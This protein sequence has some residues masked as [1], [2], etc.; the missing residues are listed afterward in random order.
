[1]KQ[2]RFQLS[3]GGRPVRTIEELRER[4]EPKDVL[5]AFRDGTLLRWA[6]MRGH[7]AYAAR[8]RGLA[9]MY[10]GADEKRLALVVE[11]LAKE[12]GIK[13][14]PADVAAATTPKPKPKQPEIGYVELVER[15][16]TNPKD[17]ALILQTLRTLVTKMGDAFPAEDLFEA[18]K[19]SDPRLVTY[20]LVCGATRPYYLPDMAEKFNFICRLEN[21]RAM[22]MET[23]FNDI[24]GVA[25]LG[26]RLIQPPSIILKCVGWSLQLRT[27]PRKDAA[28]IG[29]VEPDVLNHLK[30]CTQPISLY[31]ASG[32]DDAIYYLKVEA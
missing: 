14:K 7:E 21:L 31:S 17:S 28:W 8:V 22:V 10:A 1:M 30:V 29:T 25:R 23:R 13:I 32:T 18:L 5:D 12:L 2:I 9:E 24:L 4:F 20:L 19:K 3:L 26:K 11:A 6:E 16:C 15:I 27:K